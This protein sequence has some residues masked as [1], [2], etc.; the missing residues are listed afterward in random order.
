MNVP[1][2]CSLLRLSP[3]LT[4]MLVEQFWGLMQTAENHYKKK[5]RSTHL[6]I[7]F[8]GLYQ[9]KLQLPLQKQHGPL[10]CCHLG[11]KAVTSFLPSFKLIF[12]E[13]PPS[14]CTAP[15]GSGKNNPNWSYS[16]SPLMQ[17]QNWK[18]WGKKNQ[19]IETQV[20]EAALLMLFCSKYT[21]DYSS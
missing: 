12:Q 21:G 18:G 1:C 17:T 20:T 14:L 11:F 2:C 4:L 19:N 5:Q 3:W 9:L 16:K 8:A 13:T 15:S 6:C 7:S 10:S